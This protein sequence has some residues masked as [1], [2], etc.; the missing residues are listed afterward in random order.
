[1]SARPL[2]FLAVLAP[3]VAY[4]DD[5]VGSVPPTETAVV[6]TSYGGQTLAAD[7]VAVTVFLGG[8]VAGSPKVV[9]GA[10]VI[11]GVAPAIVHGAHGDV[12]GALGGAALRATMFSLGAYVGAAATDCDT[13]SCSLEEMLVG[14]ALGYT[15]A[16][17][18]DAQFFA[19]SKRLVRRPRVTPSV[20]VSGAGVQMGF[21]GAF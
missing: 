8:V 20:N 18:V 13:D 21:A 19:R 15:V 10:A 14:G 2:I 7:A 1:M 16:A 6:E 5:R 4:A 3:A 17:I 11:G 9:V 12:G